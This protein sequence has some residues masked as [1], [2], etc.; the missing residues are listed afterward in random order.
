[1]LIAFVI[2]LGAIGCVA[3]HPPWQVWKRSACD[4]VAERADRDRER[5]AE[6]EASK[7]RPDQL[8]WYRNDLRKTIHELDGCK[9]ERAE[10]ATH[11][12][13]TK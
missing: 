9:R 3:R 8:D 6:L 4:D 2:G 11:T 12:G 13:E 5:I 7:E 1:M 10:A